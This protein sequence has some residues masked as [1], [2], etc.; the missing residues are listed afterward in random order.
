[1]LSRILS[2]SSIIHRI[3]LTINTILTS[4]F[5]MIISPKTKE[6]YEKSEKRYNFWRLYFAPYKSYFQFIRSNKYHF[7][8]GTSKFVSGLFHAYLLINIQSILNNTIHM[9]LYNIALLTSI[10]FL[11]ETENILNILFAK[12][13]TREK[14]SVTQNVLSYM[15]LRFIEKE[16]DNQWQNKYPLSEQIRAFESAFWCYNG[17]TY[18]LFANVYTFILFVQSFVFCSYVFG[19]RFSLTILIL[20]GIVFV[21]MNMFQKKM[22]T[23]AENVGPNIEKNMNLAV[24]KY[25]LHYNR[26]INPPMSEAITNANVNIDFVQSFVDIDSS[27]SRNN[28]IS[29]V[30]TFTK[31]A[32][33]NI[34][35]IAFVPFLWNDYNAGSIDS[36]DLGKNILILFLKYPDLT[37][38][39]NIWNALKHQEIEDGKRLSFLFDMLNHRSE[40]PSSIHSFN[41]EMSDDSL[42]TFSSSHD[43]MMSSKNE[44]YIISPNKTLE[45]K[46]DIRFPIE[47]GIVLLDGPSG[48]GKSVTLH[49]LAGIAPNKIPFKSYVGLKTRKRLY[50]ELKDPSFH[51]L[52][53]HQRISEYYT[54]NR[55]ST[56][57]MT[58]RQLFPYIKSQE[59]VIEYLSHFNLDHSIRSFFNNHTYLNT[60]SCESPLD[61]PLCSK[62]E[63]MSPGEIQRYVL[64]AHIWTIV[65]KQCLYSLKSYPLYI[66]LDEYDK[67]IDEG[68]ACNILQFILDHSKTIVFLVTHNSAIKER[69][70]DCIIQR[71]DYV[72]TESNNHTKLFF[73]IH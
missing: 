22:Q 39:W 62:S 6:N 8:L 31:S 18:N 5:G 35:F 34:S 25:L 3:S 19:H 66:I 40:I 21:I 24:N 43:I 15:R 68:T 44:Q 47:K 12:K 4:M 61:I 23:N 64:A 53:I 10:M 36:I 20:N 70:K 56:I 63:E 50:V 27:W 11:P 42:F 26:Y 16:R 58:L 49:I 1:M 7:I 59:E 69:F 46:N 13:L 33:F 55:K 54:K 28:R 67:A 71:W 65:N 41:N 51:R 52:Y 37:G 45:F 72:Q 2:K 38:L 57:T 73:N 9:D 14:N 30:R 29:N 60:N 48:C 32:I 17:V